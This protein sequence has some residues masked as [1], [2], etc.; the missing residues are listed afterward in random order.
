MLIFVR[1]CRPNSTS[2]QHASTN[3]G[4]FFC[5]N[6][7]VRESS[8]LWAERLRLLVHQPPFGVVFWYTETMDTF[9]GKEILYPG[10]MDISDDEMKFIEL[11]LNEH[12][13]KVAKLIYKIEHIRGELGEEEKA[14][15][16]TT[17]QPQ[18]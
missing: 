8:E 1:L 7:S 17:N 5:Y 4:A 9:G 10:E 16:D 11:L 15:D 12:F 3:V 13:N 6:R 2:L 18:Q 14:G